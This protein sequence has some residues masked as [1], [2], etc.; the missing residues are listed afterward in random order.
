MEYY[1]DNNYFFITCRTIDGRNYFFEENIRN[2][3]LDI[4]KET[5]SQYQVKFTA[6]SIL[7]N[8]YHFLLHLSSGKEISKIVRKINGNVSHY[9]KYTPKPLLSVYYNSNVF[10]E[11]S[12]YRVLGYVAGN[13]F[14]H[15]L[16]N[17]LD[18]LVDYK[19][20][21]Y[22]YLVAA[23]GVET[24]K[25]IICHVQRLNWDLK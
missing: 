17:N 1:L 19:F 22:R 13:P 23:Y 14:K 7:L 24:I 25:Q 16:V 8:H 3:I 5:E 11:P 9:L 18:G 4:F 12:F 21:N 20:S 10:N 15:G 6:Y 2:F